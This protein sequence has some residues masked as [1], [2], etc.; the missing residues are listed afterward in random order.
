MP[1][2]HGSKGLFVA[3]LHGRLRASERKLIVERIEAALAATNELFNA[4]L[5]ISKLDAGALNQNVAVFPVARLLGHIE[6]TFAEAAREKGISLRVV[7]S[8]AWIRSDF[9]LLERIVFNLISN[10]IR[11]T[12]SG[13]VI[14]GCRKRKNGVRIEV[15]DS[16]AG[17]PL[18]E[19]EKI[20]G[21]FYRFGEPDRESA[22]GL[23]LGLAIVDRLCRLLDHS[24][25]VR[26]IPGRGSVFAVTIPIAP[27]V[28][29]PRPEIRDR[30]R[31]E[32]SKDKLVLVID[33]DP[34][35]LEGM[36]GILR[37]WGC[38]VITADTDSK[39]LK[40]LTKES[41]PPDLIISD[42]HLSS[43]S[44]GLEIIERL[45]TAL[46]L[47]IPAFLISGD[48]NPEPANEAEARGFHILHKPVSPM[49]LRAMLQQALKRHQPNMAEDLRVSHA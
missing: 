38:H 34:F 33:D 46:S 7:G 30:I 26:S 47:Q 15:W 3:L 6:T 17:I 36:D 28:E 41:H 4:L 22:G 29:M 42:Y 5:D 12:H 49:A 8:S 27:A 11:Y 44:T 18:D 45:R 24:R 25:E 20:F 10:A 39:A 43:G 2:S 48:I 13:G 21:E 31:S 16:G 1:A 32:I 14:V 19:Q 23:G 9:I 35:T 40:A 37:S